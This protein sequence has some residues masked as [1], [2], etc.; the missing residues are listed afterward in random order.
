M[1]FNVE[2]SSSTKRDIARKIAATS[3]SMDHLPLPLVVR[4]VTVTSRFATALPSISR[5]WTRHSIAPM[6]LKKTRTN[7][8]IAG[9]SVIR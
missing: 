6:A 3:G 9:P 1:S 5:S 8:R 4:T 2:S 7:C